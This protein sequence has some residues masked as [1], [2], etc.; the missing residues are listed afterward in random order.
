ML[1]VISPLI[2]RGV[3]D[4]SERDLIDLRLWCIDGQEPLHFRMPGNCLRDIAGCRVNFRN[5]SAFPEVKELPEAICKLRRERHHIL[6]GD[7]TLSRRAPEN[8]NRGFIAN[9]L[10]IELFVDDSTRMLIETSDFSY[11][12]SLPQWQMSDVDNMV[13]QQINMEALRRHVADNV[14][15]YRAPIIAQRGEMPPCE[16]D[17]KLNRAEAYMSIYPTIKEKYAGQPGG[18]LAACYVMERMAIMSKAA[19]SDEQNLPPSEWE[20]PREWN[21]LD[22]LEPQDAPEVE[23]AMQTPLF[24]EVSRMTAVVQEYIINGDGKTNPTK[25]G[26]A[27]TSGYAGVVSHILSTLLL[28]RQEKYSTGLAMER[29]GIISK[30]LRNLM[31]LCRELPFKT[32]QT[33]Q[34]AAQRLL[35]SLHDFRNTIQH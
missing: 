19:E 6:P 16:W 8:D 22:F 27:F 25:E 24:Q 34:Q 20:P 2:K 23:A 1:A 31:Q 26:A 18:Y 3:I 12:L 10:S 28:T 14:A 35:Q 15:N 30:R 9:F 4:N 32:S 17:D 13:Q 5:I 11:E 33:V 21:V 7:I 29:M